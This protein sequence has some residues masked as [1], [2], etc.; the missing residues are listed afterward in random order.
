MILTLI[1]W[2]KLC[3]LDFSTVQ[4]WFFSF[5]M[6]FFRRRKL[7]YIMEE[8]ESIYFIWH[9]SER[10][11]CPFLY[12]DINFNNLF[13]SLYNKGYLVQNHYY[14]LLL[15]FV[16]IIVALTISFMLSGNAYTPLCPLAPNPVFWALCASIGVSRPFLYLLCSSP[17]ISNFSKWCCLLRKCDI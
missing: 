14:Q 16:Y 6:L 15:L 11:I 17:R 8:E 4:L 13:I 5:Y 9:S 3:L 2:L 12:I 10:R 1:I 7:S